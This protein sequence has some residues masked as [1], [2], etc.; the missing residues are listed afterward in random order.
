M[1]PEGVAYMQTKFNDKKMMFMMKRK[2]HLSQFKKLGD[3][4]I[5]QINTMVS[6]GADMA[7]EV[8]SGAMLMMRVGHNM[9][10]KW[11]CKFQEDG[12]MM[13]D[14]EN[15]PKMENATEWIMT[16]GKNMDKEV[17]K[18]MILIGTS[19][20]AAAKGTDLDPHMMRVRRVL[21]DDSE[22]MDFGD[23]NATAAE[24]MKIMMM[25][26]TK[27]QFDYVTAKPSLIAEVPFAKIRNVFRKMMKME[28]VNMIKKYHADKLAAFKEQ[29]ACFKKLM[30]VHVT[31]QCAAMT[32][33]RMFAEM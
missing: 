8:L 4:Y 26:T 9:V 27:Q 22:M 23:L 20:E 11:G 12:S 25:E 17:L 16:N 2:A 28:L 3:D 30:Q 14:E 31:M 10:V 19:L 33:N 13:I 32:A 6:T 7:A 21:E 24:W 15:C 29:R 18:R 1:T 5:K